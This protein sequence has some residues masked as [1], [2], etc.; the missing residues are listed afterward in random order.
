MGVSGTGTES[1]Q[2][3]VVGEG[4]PA[5]ASFAGGPG[6]TGTGGAGSTINNPGSGVENYLTRY[7][8]EIT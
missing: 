7:W 1:K 6:V 8:D 2:A 4:G 3:G 5:D